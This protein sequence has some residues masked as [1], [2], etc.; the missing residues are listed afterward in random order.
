MLNAHLIYPINCT[1]KYGNSSYLD[2]KISLPETKIKKQ[3]TI[4][5][6]NNLATKN[7]SLLNYAECIKEPRMG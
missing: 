4:I 7:K 2:I 5:R 3:C 6:I 1:A